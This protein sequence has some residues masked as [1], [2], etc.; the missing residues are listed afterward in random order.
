MQLHPDRGV[1]AVIEEA[2]RA[3]EQGFDSVW[4]SDHI[5]ATSGAHKADG[6]L[7]LFVL[8]TA[9]AAVTQRTRLAWAS[10][11]STLRPPLL[12]A[13]MLSTLDVISHGRLICSLGSGWNK[14]E[15]SAYNLP[16]ID[17]HD[18]RAEYAR[19]FIDSR[20][21]WNLSKQ[22]LGWIRRELSVAESKLWSKKP[23]CKNNTAA[24]YQGGCFGF[25]ESISSCV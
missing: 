12:F 24:T 9:I 4:L 23:H 17:D 22:G 15:W 1:D 6:P 19:E 10:L 20:G 7:D 8:M 11:N 18:E 5:M 14:E 21:N 13:K 2:R 25:R 16:L 3:D